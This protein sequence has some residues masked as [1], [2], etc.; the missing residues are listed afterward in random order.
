MWGNKFNNKKINLSKCVKRFGKN[1]KFPDIIMVI[2][3]YKLQR[4]EDAQDR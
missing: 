1:I 4:I 2:A 3:K